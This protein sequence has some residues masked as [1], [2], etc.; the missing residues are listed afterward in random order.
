MNK[1]L[2]LVL[3]VLLVVSPAMAADG[4]ISIQSNFSVK[5]TAGRLESILKE[6]LVFK[7]LM[8]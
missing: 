2:F 5:E 6:K 1:L 8:M 4:M 3:L 7:S